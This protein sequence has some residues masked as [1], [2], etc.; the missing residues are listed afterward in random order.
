MLKEYAM[1]IKACNYLE[2]VGDHIDDKAK[3]EMIDI[4]DKIDKIDTKIPKPK[5]VLLPKY[6][7][8]LVARLAKYN[9]NLA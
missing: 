8:E 1:M 6:K 4:V 3:K 9:K 5:R 7:R 2:D